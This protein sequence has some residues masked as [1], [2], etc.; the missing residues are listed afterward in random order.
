M[1]LSV[2]QTEQLRSALVAVQKLYQSVAADT[3]VAPVV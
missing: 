1:P 2:G 3:P